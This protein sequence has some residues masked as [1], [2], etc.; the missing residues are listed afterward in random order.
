MQQEKGYKVHGAIPTYY[1]IERYKT[2][3][4]LV[5]YIY[6]AEKEFYRILK[7][8]GTLWLRWCEMRNMTHNQVLAIFQ[9]W[10]LLLTHELNSSK[11]V[12]SM[13]DSKEDNISYWF[14]L[15]K[16]PLTFQQPELL[17]V[18]SNHSK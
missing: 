8:E 5:A 11:Q 16:K 1:G 12:L 2:R 4:A 13:R 17:T 14:M 7:N 9:N 3:S 6:R 10:R 15:M 18:A